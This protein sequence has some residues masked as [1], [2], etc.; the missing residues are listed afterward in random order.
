MREGKHF[1]TREGEFREERRS[2]RSSGSRKVISALE[3]ASEGEDT[4]FACPVIG[5]MIRSLNLRRSVQVHISDNSRYP[6]GARSC[7]TYC[8]HLN[9]ISTKCG[10]QTFRR[11]LITQWFLKYVCVVY[12]VCSP[13]ILVQFQFHF[14]L[15]HRRK[16]QRE[17]V[18]LCSTT[19]FLPPYIFALVVCVQPN[20]S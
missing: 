20:N 17:K 7:S 5:Q 9:E 1:H 6:R 4:L 3:S 2:Q 12:K 13:G 8:V 16:G 18:A 10:V 14:I 15:L 11:Y 19:S